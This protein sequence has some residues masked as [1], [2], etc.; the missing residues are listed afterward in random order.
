M[1]SLPKSKTPPWDGTS[2]IYL[3]GKPRMWVI[4]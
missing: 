3:L 2:D 4:L 1:I